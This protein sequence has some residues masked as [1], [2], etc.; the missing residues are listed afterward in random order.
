MLLLFSTASLATCTSTTLQHVLTRPTLSFIVPNHGSFATPI[1]ACYDRVPRRRTNFKIP[2]TQT[3]SMAVTNNKEDTIVIEMIN[4]DDKEEL[5]RMS[6]FCIDTFYNNDP[7]STGG[8]FSRCVSNSNTLRNIEYLR[9]VHIKKSTC[10]EFIMV[11]KFLLLLVLLSF[12]YFSHC[13]K[14]E[15][16]QVGSITK[17][18][19]V[20]KCW[21]LFFS[22]HFNNQICVESFSIFPC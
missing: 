3:L 15:G 1:P 21:L 18:A 10:L 9:L 16:Y 22:F 4:L 5:K 14:M 12:C 17:G 7:N 6:Q 13:K 19:N 2:K 8:N 11:Y 20:G